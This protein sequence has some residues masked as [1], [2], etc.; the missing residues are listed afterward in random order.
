MLM[1]SRLLLRY[2]QGPYQHTAH[3]CTNRRMSPGRV[4][5]AECCK[6]KCCKESI[7]GKI[8]KIKYG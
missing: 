2:M 1:F 3:L 8:D 6:Q 5:Q 7:A 4:L